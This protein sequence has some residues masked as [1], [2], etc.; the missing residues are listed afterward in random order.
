M[1]E[2]SYKYT[3]QAVADSQQGVVLKFGGLA[4]G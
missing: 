2:V 1:A 4:K 3:E